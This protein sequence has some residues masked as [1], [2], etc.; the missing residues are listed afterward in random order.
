M[1]EQFLT[2]EVSRRD[3]NAASLTALFVGMT[4][5]VG[6]CGKSGSNGSSTYSASPTAPTSTPTSSAPAATPAASDKAGSIADNHGHEAMVTAVQLQAAG[7]VSLSI[8]GTADHDHSVD[9]TAEQVAQVA[10]GS[11]VTKSST[12]S[13]GGSDGYG[14]YSTPNHSHS[15]TFN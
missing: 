1:A 7:G 6:A 2:R 14:G 15:V 4:V 13:L 11:R 10:A 12:A 9:L 8:R 5:W 3:F